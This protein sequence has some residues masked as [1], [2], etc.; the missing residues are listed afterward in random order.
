[1]SIRGQ[2]IFTKVLT[3]DVITFTAEMGI[4]AISIVLISGAGSFSGS[5][6]VGYLASDPI[7]LIVNQSVDISSDSGLPLEGVIVDC[8]GGGIINIIGRE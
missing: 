4:T 7:N 3:T 5:L 8:S 2:K 6:S 1:M